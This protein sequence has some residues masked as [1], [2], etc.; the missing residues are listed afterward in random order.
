MCIHLHLEKYNGFSASEIDLNNYWNFK[1][2][3]KTVNI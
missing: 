2:D 1:K 3:C